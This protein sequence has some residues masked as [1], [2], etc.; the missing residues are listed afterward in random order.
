MQGRKRSAVVGTAG[1]RIGLRAKDILT[2]LC[3]TGTTQGG[4]SSAACDAADDH[5]QWRWSE[6]GSRGSLTHLSNGHCLVDLGAE[7]LTTA[8]LRRRRR[9]RLAD[10]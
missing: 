8:A 3:L 10:S 4:L 7:D 1:Q 2:G 9:P 5:Q 6:Q